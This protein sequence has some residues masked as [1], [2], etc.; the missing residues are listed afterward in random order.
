[1][2]YPELK[3]KLGSGYSTKPGNDDAIK[4]NDQ[5]QSNFTNVVYLRDN[6]IYDYDSESV[7]TTDAFNHKNYL[8]LKYLLGPT[9]RVQNPT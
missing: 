5:I 6:S 9:P 3:Q 8:N 2:H 4:K 7:S 1:M